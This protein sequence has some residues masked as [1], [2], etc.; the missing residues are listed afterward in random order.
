[1]LFYKINLILKNN[2]PKID[3]IPNDQELVA[4][5]YSDGRFISGLLELENGDLVTSSSDGIIQT[6]QIKTGKILK[7][8]YTHMSRISRLALMTKGSSLVAMTTDL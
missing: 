1:M 4:I 3:A 8:I 6:W 5:L 7:T 2:P